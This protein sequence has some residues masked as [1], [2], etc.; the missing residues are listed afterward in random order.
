MSNSTLQAN[1]LIVAYYPFTLIIVGTLLNL[2]TFFILCRSAFKDTK[3][4]P[5]IHYMRTIAIFDILMLYGWNFDHYL[6][7]VH[8]YILLT[9]SIPTCKIFGFLNYFAGQSSAWLRVAISFDRYLSASH[10]HRTIFNREKTIL[11]IIASI[12]IFFLV[13]NLHF[14]IFTC[15][16]T[17]NGFVDPNARFYV[18]YPLWDYVNL[19]FYNCVPTLLM[20]VF[21]SRTIYHLI[22]LRRVRIIQQSAIQHQAISVTLILTTC[23]F[24]IMT[25]PATIVAAFFF[26][27]P[28]TILAKVLDSILYTYHILSFVIYFLTFNAFRHEVLALL[29]CRKKNQQQI[30]PIRTN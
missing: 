30:V 18:I 11:I 24:L 3:R 4:Q 6:Q 23:L 29:T 1:D 10:L 28:T 9:Y 14:L 22:H 8:G 2:F 17:S 20:I 15:F 27:I 16:L 21:N 25:I 5:V 7:I 13:L 19:G 12:I 26:T